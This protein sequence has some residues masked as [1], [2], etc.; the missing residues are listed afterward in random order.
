MS[1]LLKDTLDF[2]FP[3]ELLDE[4]FAFFN[5]HQ[6]HYWIENAS[7]T[8][9]LQ[10]FLY[11]LL[12]NT[13]NNSTVILLMQCDNWDP[14]K[15]P[16]K[17]KLSIGDMHYVF[18]TSSIRCL[19]LFLN[20]KHAVRFRN[21]EL[22][23]S[24][25]QINLE[26]LNIILHYLDQLDITSSIWWAKLVETCEDDE[27]ILKLSSQMKH[28]SALPQSKLE[29]QCMRMLC[30]SSLVD[31]PNLLDKFEM[32]VRKK[33]CNNKQ[34]MAFVYS[35]LQLSKPA[36]LEVLF[37]AEGIEFS[38]TKEWK[39]K[40]E[41]LLFDTLLTHWNTLPPNFQSFVQSCCEKVKKHCALNICDAFEKCLHY[42]L[43]YFAT[44]I[45]HTFENR[46]DDFQ[47][48]I[49][50]VNYLAGLVS[51]IESD[52]PPLN[53]KQNRELV[54][55]VAIQTRSERIV[56]LL[57][58][59]QLWH[60][61]PEQWTWA[62][63]SDLIC[64]Y[65][66]EHVDRFWDLIP[67]AKMQQFAP[68]LV[69]LGT[70]GIKRACKYNLDISREWLQDNFEH[71]VQSGALNLIDQTRGMRL[72]RDVLTASYRHAMWL[73]LASLQRLWEV[74]PLLDSS[75]VLA[76]M[77]RSCALYPEIGIFLLKVGAVSKN[78]LWNVYKKK[79]NIPSSTTQ[80]IFATVHF[81]VDN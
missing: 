55:R 19:Q 52:W 11:R 41:M 66:A 56:Q 28:R 76:N 51:F 20:H 1:C 25:Q 37:Y 78:D 58:K 70:T 3:T 2:F 74:H 17:H 29:V 27:V 16:F 34:K 10:T 59:H 32:M 71:V 57:C 62:F 79:K 42:G 77:C 31:T 22:F 6:M 44:W 72:H 45:W 53:I 69:S 75:P 7:R 49:K 30:K 63:W 36:R 15:Q 18:Q 54:Q 81:D 5:Q 21:L 50:S 61:H 43:V 13:T 39:N 68:E 64:R 47:R 4:L 8:T 38:I 33:K 65:P 48:K 35:A 9:E 46:Q 12:T 40:D 80:L 60:E 26:K 67:R 23:A 24:M 14:K 73:S